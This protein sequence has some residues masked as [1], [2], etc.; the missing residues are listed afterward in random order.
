MLGVPWEPFKTLWC[1]S[2]AV[3]GSSWAVWEP[4]WGPLAPSGLS[5]GF[6]GQAWTLLR[7]Q[8]SGYATNERV[9]Q[10]MGRCLPLGR[11][12]GGL[13]ERLKGLPGRLEATLGPL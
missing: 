9:H 8:I 3:L 11:Q 5:R 1:P 12:F 2:W 10:G 7:P 4:S 13:V 6:P